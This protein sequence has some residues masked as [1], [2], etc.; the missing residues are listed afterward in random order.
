MTEESDAPISYRVAYSQRVRDSLRR[1]IAGAR[2]RGLA[3]QV[4]DAVKEIDRRLHLYPQFGEPLADLTHE[5]GQVWIGTI[6]PL[7]VR[8]AIYEER[9]LVVVSVPIMPLSGAGL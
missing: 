5:S 1:L 3:Q 2:E 9:R 8:Y 7:F 4:L 6:P